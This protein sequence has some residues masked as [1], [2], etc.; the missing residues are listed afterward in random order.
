[1]M[2]DILPKKIRRLLAWMS[3]L[4]SGFGFFLYFLWTI[5]VTAR[6]ALVSPLDASILT[7]IL[8]ISPYIIALIVVAWIYSRLLRKIDRYIYQLQSDETTRSRRSS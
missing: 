3:L 5:S 7:V 4:V 2:V 6:K 8:A 1:M